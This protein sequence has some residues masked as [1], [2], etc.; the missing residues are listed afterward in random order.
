MQ[1]IIVKTELLIIIKMKKSDF[2][3]NPYKNKNLYI[4]YIYIYIY[5]E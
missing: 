2:F 1:I 4:V 3:K 5:N